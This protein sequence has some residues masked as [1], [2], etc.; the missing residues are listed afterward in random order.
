MDEI[1]E[2]KKHSSLI[3]MSNKNLNVSQRKLYNAILYLAGRQQQTDP[4]AEFFRIKFSEISKFAGYELSTNTKYLKASIDALVETRVNLNIMNKSN[5]EW[6][7][8]TLISEATI[9]KYDK[10]VTIVFPP[11]IRNNLQYPS[12]YALLNLSIVNT[13]SGKYSLQIYELVSDYKKIGKVV[14][15]LSKFRELVG[16]A[17]GEYQKISN[18]KTRVIESSIVEINSKTDL[19]VD[20]ELDQ[21][22]R[23]NEYT[24]VV[25]RIKDKYY[26]LDKV[27]ASAY[28]LLKSK[29]LPESSSK[30][31]A[32]QLSKQNIME[33]IDNLERAV[34]KG[35]VKNSTAYLTKILKN[36][37]ISEDELHEDRTNLSKPG[38]QST[39]FAPTDYRQIVDDPKNNIDF[40]KYISNKISE[41]ISVL[42]IDVFRKFIDEQNMF[43]IEY[44]TNKNILDEKKNIVNLQLLSED[45]VFRGWIEKKYVDEQIEYKLFEKISNE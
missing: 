8:F 14:I 1:V 20:Y 16:V 15:E 40:R 37:E 27:E 19:I 33:A 7:S 17:E 2:L 4:N 6:A 18:L 21:R 26:D 29:G 44:Y 22:G 28:L 43:T 13:L 11:I 30:K 42:S 35:S 31:F 36:I 34:K 45:I 10:F 12:I 32:K 38:Q 25:F 39:L 23:G 9:K 3:A 41:L 5:E 24:H